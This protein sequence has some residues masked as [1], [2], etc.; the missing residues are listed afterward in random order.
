M[1]LYGEY[2]EWKFPTAIQQYTPQSQDTQVFDV[3]GEN[4]W[5]PKESTHSLCVPVKK[6]RRKL[7]R[8]HFTCEDELP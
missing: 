7:E 8:G 4:G 5:S 1:L 6:C 3:E 2:S